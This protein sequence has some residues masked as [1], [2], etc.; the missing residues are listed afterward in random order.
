ML[1][2]DSD[3]LQRFPGFKR[4]ILKVSQRT[5]YYSVCLP[6]NESFFFCTQGV[7]RLIIASYNDPRVVSQPP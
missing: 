4:I 3:S 7:S 2:Y 6:E 1:L 5:P